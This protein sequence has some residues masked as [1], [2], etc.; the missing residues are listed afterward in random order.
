MITRK[1]SQTAKFFRNIDI[2]GIPISLS[3]DNKPVH[4]TKL[5]GVLTC[6]ILGV[7]LALT[8]ISFYKL[9]RIQLLTS[10]NYTS[11]LG[12]KYGSLLSSSTIDSDNFMIAIKTNVDS[13]NNWTSPYLNVSLSQ[14]TQIRFVN[15]SISKSS[16]NIRLVPCT[17]DHFKGL[18]SQY[19]NLGL[20]SALCPVIGSNF[21]IEGGFV[22]NTY[23]YLKISFLPC[24]DK[25][26]CQNGSALNDLIG[27]NV[28][29]AA[30]FYIINNEVDETSLDNPITSQVYSD[31]HFL[32]NPLVP[33]YTTA[34][35]FLSE[36]KIETDYSFFPSIETDIK[37]LTSHAF[38]H[39]KN[40]QSMYNNA[41]GQSV[42]ADFYLRKSQTAY[43]YKRNIGEFLQ[44]LSY[45]GGFWSSC[46]V[47]FL[48][49]FKVYAKHDFINK[50]SNRLYDYPSEEKKKT[51][52]HKI[53]T[54]IDPLKGSS[55]SRQKVIEK[56]EER[57]SYERKLKIGF[58][59]IMRYILSP[60]ICC[61]R[62]NKILLMKKS[63]DFIM[64]DLDI[65][66]I[67]RKM[68]EL[69]CMKQ[70]LFSEEQHSLLTFC[71]K[72]PIE[73]HKKIA[74]SNEYFESRRS[75]ANYLG[76]QVQFNNIEIYQR[77]IN[78]WNALKRSQEKSVLNE[79]IIKMF[80]LELRGIFSLNQIAGNFDNKLD[81]DND[82]QMVADDKIGEENKQE[83]RI[84]LE[85][86]NSTDKLTT[87]SK[88][89]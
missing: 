26:I 18:K 15:S 68:H 44:I 23:T 13:I 82:S 71:P 31:L 59:S 33:F 52:Y 32:I 35:I 39:E 14:N 2:F 5:G 21:T 54:Q 75:Y 7:F 85:T 27:K 51:C 83:I 41:N 43:Y 12:N 38:K 10:S 78:A 24:S 50:L 62:S 6:F 61:F 45:I 46:Y 37:T 70:V 20:Y 86:F 56:I 25:K 49:F 80:N 42:Y 19:Y 77:L 11:N 53:S 88:I 8:I 34:D 1:A 57:L 48:M 55:S 16:K 22:E 81:L 89:N 4:N 76:S 40:Q 87:F 73:V 60:I 72:K 36:I 47:A 28:K 9:F 84:Q 67:I 63:E 65:Y 29:F 30:D 74:Q 64:K 17:E 79:R 66:T 69:D 58:I 3:S